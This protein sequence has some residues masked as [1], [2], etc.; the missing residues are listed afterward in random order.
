MNLDRLTVIQP[1]AVDAYSQ[2]YFL[3]GINVDLSEIRATEYHVAR[4]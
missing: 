1:L 4:C 3:G 2:D